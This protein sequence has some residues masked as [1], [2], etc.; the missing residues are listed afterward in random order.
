MTIVNESSKNT[1]KEGN[2]GNMKSEREVLNF[3]Q[4]EIFCIKY[5][6]DKIKHLMDGISTKMDTGETLI[7]KVKDKLEEFS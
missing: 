4:V 3:K 1:L 6:V 7:M 5:F 2:I